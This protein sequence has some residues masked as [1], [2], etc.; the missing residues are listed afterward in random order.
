MNRTK[1]TLILVALVAL[2]GSGAEAQTLIG[3][4][5]LTSYDGWMDTYDYNIAPPQGNYPAWGVLLEKGVLMENSNGMEKQGGT[6]LG[7]ENDG[8]YKPYMMVNSAVTPSTYTITGTY[9]SWD[10]DG[11]GMIFGYQDNDNYFRLGVRRESTGNYG[12]FGGLTLSKVVGGVITP[13]IAG[14]TTS[15]VGT[16]NDT[17]F[18]LKVKVD[19]GNFEVYAS[20]PDGREPSTP[21]LSGFDADLATLGAGNYG[22]M[23]WGQRYDGTS[24][25]W[26][27][28]LH[29]MTVDNGAN[30]SIDKTHTFSN[31]SPV[32]WRKLS[33]TRAD[34]TQEANLAHQGNF[35]LD[36][37]NGVIQDDTDGY[38]MA[39]TNYTDFIG[40]A[41]VVDE[42]SAYD[43]GDMEMKVRITCDDDEGPGL[44]FRVQNDKSFYRVNLATQATGTGRPRKGLSIQ[45]CLD[46]GEGVAPTWTQLFYESSPQ[47]TYELGAN[48]VPFDISVR[49]VNNG[50]TSTTIVVEILN[51]DGLNPNFLYS[52]TDYSNP[53][54]TGTVGFTNWGA[55]I[56]GTAK[57]KYS[58]G[59]V[60]S[61]YGGDPN[62]PLVVAY[63]SAAPGGSAAAPIP[64]P[65]VLVLL[66]G[67]AVAL[68]LPRRRKTFALLLA[69]CCLTLPLAGVAEA[70][71]LI[72]SPFIT[73]YDGWTDTYSATNWTGVGDSAPLWGVLINNNALCDLSDGAA[74]NGGTYA[75][76]GA[77]D[78]QYKPWVMVNTNYTTPSKY[79]LLGTLSS[80]DDDGLGLVFGY[81][82]DN[83]Y[84]RIGMRAEATGNYGFAQGISFDKV[85]NGVVSQVAVAN[86]AN[87]GYLTDN[88]PFQLKIEVDG[89]I[90]TVSGPALLG[91]GLTQYFTGSIG[92]LSTL[93]QGHY[94]VMSWRSRNVGDASVQAV[95]RCFG[96]QLHSLTVDNNSDG[97]IE[98]N[99]TFENV[100]P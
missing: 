93:G 71:T 8:Q 67:A 34:N 17:P 65:G 98:T 21:Q 52:V 43:I 79:T 4:P 62:V 63:E 53:L 76:G 30:G 39:T 23:S 94:G 20:R 78:S 11:L 68:S 37:I 12:F 77:G 90:C 25:L 54:L 19:G 86:A 84:L 92:E 87:F 50:S 6:Y 49:A 96:A 46:N 31:A 15:F 26:G 47:F 44:L 9:S 99:H 10:N 83:N 82:D 51:P 75:G 29:S 3:S 97:S 45:K 58:G 48:A 88:T 32:A 16:S 64:E 38:E 42:P 95:K 89:T 85:V 33:M 41:I 1:F 22:A 61:G 81:Q 57:G 35:H 72:G 13:Y 60:Y 5:F 7:V 100:S 69:A 2:A 91:G 59:L 18:T 80:T 36:F 56:N 74:S 40:P 28:M 70:G 66:I 55:G 14:P 24:P 73:G 27:T